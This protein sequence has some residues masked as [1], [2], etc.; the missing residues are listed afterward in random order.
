MWCLRSEHLQLL[1]FF[2]GIHPGMHED[3]L[4][5]RVLARGVKNL[6]FQSQP[7]LNKAHDA[8]FRGDAKT[9]R[10]DDLPPHEGIQFLITKAS[11]AFFP[12]FL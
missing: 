12:L 3:P 1:K 9:L 10:G 5:C 4:R 6:V 8:G 2:I 11:H 7:N